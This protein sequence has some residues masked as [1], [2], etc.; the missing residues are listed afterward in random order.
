ML[1]Q[2]IALSLL[3]VFVSAVERV[4]EWNVT[5]VYDVD[6]T[7]TGNGRWVMGVNGK[8][9]IDPIV[10]DYGDQVV[11]KMTNQLTD[12]RTC[13]LHSHGI[14]QNHT[15]YMD[16][17]P[18]ITQCSIPPGDTFI[19]NFTALQ[20]GTYWVHSHDMSQY[21]DGLRTPFIINA[22]EEP[23]D[24]DEELIISLTDWYNTPFHELFH[25]E[26][27]TFKNPTGAEPVPDAGLMNDTLNATFAV[28]P[29]KTYRIRF[30]NIGAFNAYTVAIEDHDMT[31]I[32][33][34]GEYTK[35]ATA[36]SI[37]LSA[38]Q[39]CSVLV[40]MKNDTSRNYA[41]TA[42]M[43]ESLFD[44]IPDNYNPNVTAW[45]S[46]NN[47]SAYDVAAPVGELDWYDD[48]LL[49]PLWE[50]NWGDSSNLLQLD[51]D[52]YTLADGANYAAING[53]PFV[54]PK[55]PGIMIANST[56]FDGYNLK[57]I[58]YGPYT[59]AIVLEHLQVIDIIVNNYDT[60]IHPFHMHGHVFEVLE[61]GEEDAG[62]YDFSVQHNYSTNP[63]R[64]DTVDIWPTSYVVIRMIANN[65]GVWVFHCHI[66]WHM[67]SGLVA[68]L[69]EA[70][71][72]VPQIASPDYVRQQC[73]EQKIP[74]A[75]NAAGNTVNISDLT[76]SPSAPGEM[77][78]GWT[79]KAI[80]TVAMCVLAAL[81][82]MGSI[83]WY[84]M[85]VERINA[86]EETEKD[87]WN[88]MLADG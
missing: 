40:Q 78:A 20:N 64:R 34:D 12:N 77:P 49:E 8:W 76:G 15:A 10:V 52:F 29:G 60:G 69:V 48:T 74:I 33:V 28:T 84:G 31:I 22:K 44:V 80:A 88:K 18:Q 27:K 14:F 35:P 11:I 36:S 70:P 39:R 45:L 19:Y 65:P 6:P 25:T 81:I 17:P 67:D 66:E 23:Y 59:N 1:A 58:T 26:F 2:L 61:R 37:R 21:P 46:Y 51:F 79:S 73:L 68:T 4:Y 50:S 3:N 16:G 38:A 47:D 62:V 24:Y 55:V 72:L 87:D 54:D 83:I 75:G 57:P 42:Y 56:N 63:V 53:T 13:S 86:V 30:I 9:P 7:Q 5:D 71:E 41:I 82:G 43:D 85:Q 32:E